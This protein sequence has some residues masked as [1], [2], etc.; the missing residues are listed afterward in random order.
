MFHGNDALG[1]KVEVT[2][3]VTELVRDSK[4]LIDS[5]AAAL[6]VFDIELVQEEVALA[7][8]LKVL[9]Q[10]SDAESVIF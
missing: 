8:E 7:N 6:N 1:L 3:L 5:E 4:A 2:V 9:E 10:V